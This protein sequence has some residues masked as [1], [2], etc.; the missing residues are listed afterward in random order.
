MPVLPA[1]YSY[2][3]HSTW[4]DGTRPIAEMVAAAAAA[5]LV[6]FGMSDHYVLTPYR[7]SNA[8][9]WSMPLDRLH[10][11]AAEVQAAQREDIQ[12]RLCLE[13]DYFPETWR[14]LP[15][16]LAGIPFDCLIG[17]VH[18]ANEFPIDG[19][20]VFWTPLSQEQVDEV[21]RLYWTRIRELAE[22]GL[23]D[24]VGHLDLPKKFGFYPKADL[25]REREAALDAIA[26]AGMA[27]ELNTA[28][29]DKPCAECYPAPDLLRAARRREIPVAI[30]ADSHAPGTVT[31]HFRRAAEL[32]RGL[33]FAST[34]RF[35]QR[36]RFAVPLE[37]GREIAN[38]GI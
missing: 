12:V 2:H 23:F 36:E 11:Y 38:P 31:A 18:Y 22:C 20:A 24:L 29:W 21:H 32:L 35:R 6:E 25:A 28:G 33:G 5:G 15:G 26:A 17:S 37:L 9:E 4:S 19:N 27:I 8:S 10:D 16:R 13:T 30:S 14:D 1:P 7:A 34:V 3:N